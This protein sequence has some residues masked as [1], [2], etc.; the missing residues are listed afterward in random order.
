VIDW[1]GLPWG[2]DRNAHNTT[3]FML[4]S[5]IEFVC[6]NDEVVD[7]MRSQQIT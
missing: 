6:K 7:P 2:L 1:S 4:S 3:S 5:L